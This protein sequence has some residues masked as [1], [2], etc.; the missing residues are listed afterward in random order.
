MRCAFLSLV[1]LLAA[2]GWPASKVSGTP[3]TTIGF[4][5]GK[6]LDV[7][8]TVG[9]GPNRAYLDIDF[10]NNSP[11]G[12]AYAWQYNWS[13]TASE[14]DML[15]AVAAADGKFNIAWDPNYAGFVDNFNYGSNIGSASPWLSSGYSYWS[16]T[17]GSYDSRDSAYS[18]TQNVHWV[19][20]PS[21][22]DST[23][24][25]NV[26]DDNGNLVSSGAQD[27]LYGW[28]INGEY[29]TTNLEPVLPEASSVPEPISLGLFAPV[30]IVLLARRRTRA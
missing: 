26:Y 17:I 20:A 6:V 16:S 14:T 12:P 4:P 15:N 13:G 29:Q 2:L 27:L 3:I 11:A 7:L 9:S 18:S 24:L 25:G 23:T 21:G 30:G 22:T 19:Y 8:G 10:S 1:V 28:T 5:D